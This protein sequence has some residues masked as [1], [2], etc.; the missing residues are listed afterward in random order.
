[1]KLFRYS[2][3]NLLGLGLP[4]FVA[5]FTIPIL[6]RELGDARFGLLTLVWAIVSY[7][8]LFDLGLG[9]ALTQQVSRALGA[10]QHDQIGA[11]IGTATVVMAVLGVGA[12]IILAVCAPLGVDLIKS[13]PDRRELLYSIYAMALAMPFIVLSTGFRGVLE[14]RHAFGIINLIRLP[15]GLFTFVGPLL[16]V[17]YW[18]PSLDYVAAALSLGRI[19]ACLI[20]GYLAWKVLDPQ[21]Q[22]LRWEAAQ[23]KPLCI[24]GSWLTISNVI[25][26]FM[27]YVDRFVIGATVSV[28]AVAHYVTPQELVTKLWIVPG[29][30]TAVLFPAFAAQINQGHDSSWGLFRK[31]VLWIFAALLP[32][33]AALAIFANE[34][35][36]FWVGPDFAVQ[37]APLLQIFAI[38]IFVN[39]LAHVPFTLIQ[40]AGAA[41]LTA[42]IHA[43]ELPFFL[44]ML[45]WLTS[46]Y[47]V[48]GAAVTWLLRILVDTALMFI[49]SAPMLGKSN[50]SM[51][52]R[53][54]WLLAAFA[55]VSFLGLLITSISGRITWFVL[56]VT[57]ATYAVFRSQTKQ[58]ALQLVN[59]LTKK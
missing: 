26:P 32:I 6:I 50:M 49:I 27:G 17:L 1:M 56:I 47:G 11:L 8:G 2:I 48:V 5:V 55:I 59:R 45:W 53:S 40:G 34:L 36:S 38:G 28:A 9:R 10:D 29:A 54:A 46:T 58:V 16:V 44:L 35:L 12:G 57:V 43:A 14:A 7:F 15:M 18:Q 22:E 37:S 30:I 23:V 4:L 13:V 24:A 39:C 52:P 41:R 42:T 25:S 31:S 51:V 19:I 3:Y 33:T 21:H 20:Y